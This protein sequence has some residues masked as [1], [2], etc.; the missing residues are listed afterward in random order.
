[1]FFKFGGLKR[2][3]LNCLTLWHM[4]KVLRNYGEGHAV[5]RRGSR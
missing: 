1:M 2:F 5:V 4:V 3:F